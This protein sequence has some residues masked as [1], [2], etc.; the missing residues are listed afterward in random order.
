MYDTAPNEFI[1]TDWMDI[2]LVSL[3]WITPP[4]KLAVL[5]AINQRIN[6][7]PR[8]EANAQ[9]PTPGQV[10]PLAGHPGVIRAAQVV[11]FPDQYRDQAEAKETMR[12]VDQPYIPQGFFTAL[13][14]RHEAKEPVS[15]SEVE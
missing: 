3:K 7:T 13:P 12:S 10:D 14:A 1:A 4:Q 5:G 11:P 2:P 15:P 8:P 9:K 6:S